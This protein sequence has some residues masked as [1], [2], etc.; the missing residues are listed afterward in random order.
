LCCLIARCENF[1]PFLVFLPLI[2]KQQISKQRR[3]QKMLKKYFIGLVAVTVLVVLTFPLNVGAKNIEKTITCPKC[4]RPQ[5]EPP[6]KGEIRN[7]RI[8]DASPVN[9][10]PQ[11]IEPAI[12]REEISTLQ[13]APISRLQNNENASTKLKPRSAARYRRDLSGSKA[14]VSSSANLA[15]IS[16]NAGTN[17]TQRYSYQARIQQNVDRLRQ[18][19]DLRR[20]RQ[21]E[22]IHDIKDGIKDGFTDDILS[23]SPLQRSHNKGGG[24]MRS[25]HTGRSHGGSLTQTGGNARDGGNST[26]TFDDGVITQMH[27]PSGIKIDWFE[28]PRPMPQEVTP[29]PFRAGDGV[30][31]NPG[32]GNEGGEIIL[33]DPESGT[34][35]IFNK[36]PEVHEA[37]S[38]TMHDKESGV[39]IDFGDHGDS[40]FEPSE[41]K[42][43]DSDSDSG[44]DDGGTDDGGTDDGGTDDGGTDDGGTDDGGTDDGGTDDGGTDDGGTDDGG[45]D[46]GSKDD[47]GTDGGE[48]EGSGGAESSP[49]PDGSSGCSGPLCAKK[50]LRTQDS[51]DEPEGSKNGCVSNGR[52]VEGENCNSSKPQP[53]AQGSDSEEDNPSAEDYVVSVEQN[54]RTG[55]FSPD[56]GDDRFNDTYNTGYS[57]YNPFDR[58]PLINPDTK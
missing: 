21:L 17:R 16:R 39:K 54:R 11:P 31:V 52:P 1:E 58:L 20:I 38:F 4:E 3:V 36:K 10:S 12:S 19:R 8:K 34:K 33:R 56:D 13:K 40:T 41:P 32:F 51:D 47:I 46:D 25:R 22:E 57:M 26:V 27:E 45:T 14:T 23:N 37:G 30:E 9:V 50:D 49:S 5:Q 2:I 15:N 7:L 42:Q 24:F 43:E 6:T 28:R 29:S 44:T 55:G 53:S 48:E 18:A 35:I